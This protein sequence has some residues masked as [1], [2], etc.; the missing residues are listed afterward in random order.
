VRWQLIDP[1]SGNYR[2]AG[3]RLF[4]DGHVQKSGIAGARLMG[5]DKGGCVGS[6]SF[7][8][9]IYLRMKMWERTP[10]RYA[11]RYISPLRPNLGSCEVAVFRG[12]GTDRVPLELPTTHTHG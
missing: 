6:L 8:R 4:V 11:Q 5:S 1:G 2:S 3:L 10:L 7:F 12:G 9:D